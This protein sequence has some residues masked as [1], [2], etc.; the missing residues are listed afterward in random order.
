MK[1]SF[2]F[3]CTTKAVRTIKYQRTCVWAYQQN[4]HWYGYL[5][6]R[7]YAR[8]HMSEYRAYKITNQHFTRSSTNWKPL[9]LACWQNI[10]VCQHHAE[11]RRS[12]LPCNEDGNYESCR[13]KNHVAAWSSTVWCHQTRREETTRLAARCTITICPAAHRSAPNGLSFNRSDVEVGFIAFHDM[14]LGS[15][16][17]EGCWPFLISQSQYLPFKPK[18]F[19]GHPFLLA[20]SCKQCKAMKPPIVYPLLID[21]R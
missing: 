6:L 2:R 13:T 12:E 17:S 3:C 21:A 7:G 20:S 9:Q 4:F 1:L 10:S 16:E 18:L 8:T 15:T 11:L 19:K 5:N 14:M